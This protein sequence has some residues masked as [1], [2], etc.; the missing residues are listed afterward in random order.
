MVTWKKLQPMLPLFCYYKKY[1]K[2]K[3]S[4]VRGRDHVYWGKQGTR[5][6]SSMLAELY[7]HWLT[8]YEAF[9]VLLAINL[10]L[11]MS[12]CFWLWAKLVCLKINWKHVS[13]GKQGT[14]KRYSMV[15]KPYEHQLTS[16]EAFCVISAINCFWL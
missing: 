9:C 7:D 8:S 1:K 13:W 10:L 5:K 11:A 12:I 4:L 6:R 3:K 14:R 2:K 16:Y 15:S